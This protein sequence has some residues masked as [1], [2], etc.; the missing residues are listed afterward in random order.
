MNLNQYALQYR[1][2]MKKIS[3]VDDEI[4][5]RF[6][7]ASIFRDPRAELYAV[8]TG[9]EALDAVRNHHLDLCFLDIHL[10]DLNGLDIMKALRSISPWTR[11]IV[12]TGSLTTD[13][14]MGSIRDNAHCLIAKP[15]D[16]DEVGAVAMRLLAPGR[17]PE[18]DC[19]LVPK[20]SC[21]IWV[22][23]E[24]RKHARRPGDRDL[25]CFVIAPPGTEDPLTVSA[26][27]VDISE[28]G[29]CILTPAELQRGHLVRSNDGTMKGGGIVRWSRPAGPAG[30]YHAGIQFVARLHIE[31]LMGTSG[32]GRP[33]DGQH[34][35]P[36]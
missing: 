8:E 33:G 32:A 21:V 17:I 31:Y 26:K 9:I 36:A 6:S 35:L 29:M 11:I 18:G 12:M 30:S 22:A 13:A 28:S 25:D 24:V 34:G 16:L 23:D 15:F 19:G 10:S 14:M 5:I 20:E 27:L 1:D 3:I 2:T 4:L 7:L